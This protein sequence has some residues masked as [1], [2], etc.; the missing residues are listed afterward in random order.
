MQPD[1]VREVFELCQAEGIHTALDTSGV[2]FND[3]VEAVLEHTDLVLLDIKSIDA[4]TFKSLTTGNLADT[5]KFAK[6]LSDNNIPIWIRHVLVP[7]I[8][9]RDDHL[10][11]LA[12]FLKTLKTVERVEV[13]PFH[14]MG[15]FKWEELGLSYELGDT[16][17]PTKERVENA[18]K[19]FADRGLGV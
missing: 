13:L 2:I 8:T 9:D 3:K 7:N 5:L 11:A 19:I 1:F 6:Y 14:K 12:D 15:E 16:D 18:K 10:T 4:A 17:A